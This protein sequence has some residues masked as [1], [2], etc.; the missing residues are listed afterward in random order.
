MSLSV[1]FGVSTWLWVSPFSNKDIREIFDK[2]AHMGFDALEIAIED[3]DIIDPVAVQSAIQEYQLPVIACGAFGPTRD[4][5]H[6]DTGIHDN[7]FRYIEKCLSYCVAWNS[8]FLAGPMYSAV[9]KARMVPP[10]QRLAE[11][12]LA[13]R[14]LRIV[15]EMA[16]AKQLQIALEPLNRFETDLVNT[17]ADMARL[18]SDIGHPAAKIMLDSFHMNIEEPDI[19]KAFQVAGK[20]LIHVQVSENYRGTPGTGQTNWPAYRKGMEAI[21]YTGTISIESFTPK[22][23]ELAGAVCFWRP[24]AENQDKFASDGLSFLKQLY[25]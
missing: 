24:M 6:A 20:D 4:L 16:E 13:V 18:I 23:Q 3:P 22:N 9:G 11:W 21:N 7:C 15:C 8:G 10:E 12:H 5:T 14:N 1:K 17:A 19:V 25:A 2:V